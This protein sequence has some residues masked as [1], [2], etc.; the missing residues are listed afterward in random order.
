MAKG[1]MASAK[2]MNAKRGGKGSKGMFSRMHGRKG[3]KR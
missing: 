1:R 2:M 3:K